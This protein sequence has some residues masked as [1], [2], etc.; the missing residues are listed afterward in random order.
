MPRIPLC[1]LLHGSIGMTEVSAFFA[2]VSVVTGISDV[3][4]QRVMLG[5]GLHAIFDGAVVSG[6]GGEFVPIEF[7]WLFASRGWFPVEVIV[8]DLG[9]APS[10]LPLTALIDGIVIAMFTF[11]LYCIILASLS[12]PIFREELGD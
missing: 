7:W 6:P 9:S 8:V 11:Q 1:M 5:E 10:P 12:S 4:D 3:P 2:L